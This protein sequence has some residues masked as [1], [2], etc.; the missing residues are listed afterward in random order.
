MTQNLIRLQDCAVT[1]WANGGGVTTELAAKRVGR[2]VVW[3]ISVARI[4]RDGPFSRFPGMAR[5]HTIIEGAGL[6]LRGESGV[7]LARPFLPLS[8]DGA[9]A[10]N[11]RLLDGPCR[12]LN[13]IYNPKDV[14]VVVNVFANDQEFEATAGEVIFVASG[15]AR[16]SDKTPLVAGDAMTL[17]AAVTVSPA[18]G[19]K[20]LRVCF[21]KAP[22]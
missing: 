4:D 22:T 11:A 16:M 1:P 21:G 5:V 20:I 18:A 12:A 13:V 17:N 14:V 19:A 6:D 10:L 7:L 8:F 15:M 3:R 2:H 9:L